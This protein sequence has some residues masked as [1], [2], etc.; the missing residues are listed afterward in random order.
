MRET[1]RLELNQAWEAIDT[2]TG[3]S[4]QEIIRGSPSHVH[5]LSSEMAEG[6]CSS[7]VR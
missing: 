5:S 4:S 3:A 2:Q 1:F 6:F 7:K